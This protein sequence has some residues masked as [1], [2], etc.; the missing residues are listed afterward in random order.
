MTRLFDH[1]FHIM[2]MAV[3]HSGQVHIMLPIVGN[4]VSFR[5]GGAWKGKA[6]KRHVLVW[7]D[8]ILGEGVF[9]GCAI[10]VHKLL[11][12]AKKSGDAVEDGMKKKPLG[13]EAHFC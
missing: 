5:L 7:Q 6:F 2:V 12:V 3:V 9:N 1:I 11:A 10:G 4:A 8:D 13:V